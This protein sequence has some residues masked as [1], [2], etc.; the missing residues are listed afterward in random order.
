MRGLPALLLLLAAC[1]TTGG[2]ATLEND[3]SWARSFD[4]DRDALYHAALGV[5]LAEGYEVE[6][7]NPLGGSIRARSA[8]RESGLMVRYTIA[9]VDVES[10]DHRPRVRIA[11][12]EAREPKG[13][14]RRPN[15]DRP[16][17]DREEYEALFAKIGE[18]LALG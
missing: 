8:I 13:A 17:R 10:L 11:L 3:G 6:S 1:G 9:R 2:T 14:G 4:A 18:A 16:V 15:D 5:L 12:V 7:A